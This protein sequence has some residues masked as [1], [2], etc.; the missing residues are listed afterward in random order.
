MDKQILDVCC[1]GKMFYCDKDDCRV[2]FCDIKQEAVRKISNGSYFGVTPDKIHDFRNMDFKDASFS[3]VIFDPPHLFCGKKSFMYTKYGTLE[4][5]GKWKEDLT[6]GFA[7]GM[8][9]LKPYGTLVFKWNEDQ[10]RLKEILPLF[11][12]KP[13]FGHKTNKTHFLVFMKLN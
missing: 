9:I 6:K 5:F 1:G 4:H 3:L 8:R 7:E 2:L 11:G 13:L 10:I 12:Q